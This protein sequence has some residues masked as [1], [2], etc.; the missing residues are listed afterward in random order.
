MKII[1]NIL[2]LNKA[3]KNFKNFGFVPTMG[4]IHQGHISLIKNSQKTCKKTIVSIFINPT[5]FNSR[6]DYKKYPKNINRDI[7]ILK[8]VKV[9]FL[10]IPK[11]KEIYME[12]NKNIKLYKKD[13]ILCAKFRKGHFE[14]V[15][16]V[17]TRL[18]SII[19]AKKIFMGEK[20]FQQL[21][22]IKK[23]LSKK[24]KVKIINC[25]TIRDKN[26]VALSTRNKLLHRTNYKK[27]SLIA[28][29]LLNLKK[30]L[31]INN[32]NLSLV[33]KKNIEKLQLFYKIKIDY[34]E[35]R[36]EKDLSNAK[37]NRKYKLFIAYNI[38]NVRLIDNF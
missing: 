7:N 6:N 4:G 22:L 25:P 5:Q 3:I 27:V 15:L 18:M 16:N 8:S 2:D 10:F 23:Y 19:K 28:K 33:I 1:K 21:Y 29:F 24:F 36:N 30:N 34:L 12:K 14:G 35:F 31:N 11:I 38:G 20:D 13:K 37:S 32:K 17:M 9:D 26:K